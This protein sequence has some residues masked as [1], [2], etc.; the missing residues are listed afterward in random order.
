MDERGSRRRR[1]RYLDDEIAAG[2]ERNVCAAV[3]DLAGPQVSV[4]DLPP[5][6]P[7]SSF[8]ERRDRTEHR[9]RLFVAKFNPAVWGDPWADASVWHPYAPQTWVNDAP[10][11]AIHAPVLASAMPGDLIV[12]MRLA[13]AG[14]Y[15]DAAGK[16]VRIRRQDDPSPF[17]GQPVLMGVW[18]VVRRTVAWQRGYP[19]RPVTTLLHLPLVRFDD[20]DAVRLPSLFALDPPMAQ[21]TPFATPN[22][23]L[24]DCADGDEE[25]RLAAAC[26]LPSDVFTEPDLYALQRRLRTMRCG[27]QD[28]HRKYW[29]DMKY[30]HQVRH[31]IEETA[32][33]VAERELARDGW[34][35]DDSKQAWP[36]WGG[37]LD[38]HRPAPGRTFERLAVEVKGTRHDPWSGH[39]MLQRSQRDRAERTALN[40]PLPG[41]RGYDWQLRV[42]AGIP[43]AHTPPED[44]KLPL[45]ETWSAQRVSQEWPPDCVK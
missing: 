10:A 3:A 16:E 7:W 1:I 37:D 20:D 19:R 33:R 41:E 29:K 17:D 18:H 6:R 45:L 21:L 39:V 13:Y 14:R 44:A 11:G 25:A 23:T 8:R 5:D 26:S 22:W 9:R 24:V 32:V 38:C 35:V 12:V 34:F 27:M 15:D 4:D 43:P 36:G 31:N 2:L 42:Q 40:R 28:R 30:R